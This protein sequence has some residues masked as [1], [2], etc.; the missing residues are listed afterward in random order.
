MMITL[1]R[2]AKE[3]GV[4]ESTVSRI[5]NRKGGSIKFSAATVEQVMKAAERLGYQPNAAARAL[6][7][8]RTGYIGFI[9]ADNIQG[10]WGNQYFAGY[11]SGVE[12]ACRR[13]GYGLNIC[14]YN[15]SNLES[16]VFPQSVGQRSV[17]GIILCG[18]TDIAVVEKFGEAN[19]PAVSIGTNIISPGVI[20]IIS[21]DTVEGYWKVA[22]HCAR[23]GHRRM[24]MCSADNVATRFK[25]ECFA[26]RLRSEP[27]TRHMT[28]DFFIPPHGLIDLNAAQPLMT[29]WLSL[30]CEKRPTVIL[31]SDQLM[32]GLTR[33]LHSRGI[34]CPEEVS[35]VSGTD[36]SICGL[37]NPALTAIHYNLEAIAE[38]AVEM[39]VDYLDRQTPMPLQ[40]TLKGEFDGV[41]IERE[42]CGPCPNI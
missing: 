7:T 4:Q 11:L 37:T 33:E 34:K 2:I 32:A 40:Q 16:F 3:V 19:I 38:S 10:G 25:T 18:P 23:L 39:L 24:L 41:I 20:P 31:G 29:H 28:L 22:R 5:L 15:L 42:S 30:P 6:A 1:K 14:L 13:Y 36:T 17:D 8:K 12:R 27:E 26:E 35:L 21:F 9:L